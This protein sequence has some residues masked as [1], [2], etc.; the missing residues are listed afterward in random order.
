MKIPRVP[1][2]I[3][4]NVACMA[5]TSARAFLAMM[6]E[7]AMP[8]RETNPKAMPLRPAARFLPDTS[9][10]RT[11]PTP[12]MTSTMPLQAAGVGLSPRNSTANTTVS[13]CP[14]SISRT[15]GR[16]PRLLRASKKQVS[17]RA[18]PSN[19]L[20]DE[21]DQ[22]LPS[23]GGKTA[24]GQDHGDENETDRAFDQGHGQ[25]R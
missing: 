13:T 4:T 16:G 10:V 14:S 15:S 18:M 8:R 19:P 1:A 6:V 24:E 20:N 23:H 5:E 7:A 25:R 17:L 21:Q 9:A 11:T 2:A 12:D 22:R 3:L